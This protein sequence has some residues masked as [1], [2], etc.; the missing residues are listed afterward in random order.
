[1]SEQQYR[2]REGEYASTPKTLTQDEIAELQSA[3]LEGP[4]T[5]DTRHKAHETLLEMLKRPRAEVREAVKDAEPAEEEA[6]SEEGM[7]AEIARLK[8]QYIQR[9]QRNQAELEAVL[10]DLAALGIDTSKKPAEIL[11]AINRMVAESKKEK[12]E[13]KENKEDKKK[14]TKKEEPAAAK[15]AEKGGDHGHGHGEKW[16][17]PRTMG[18]LGWLALATAYGV[19]YTLRFFWQFV[20]HPVIHTAGY[21]LSGDPKHP[22]TS[23]W[24]GFTGDIKKAFGAGKAA[25]AA[26]H[27]GGGG[28]GH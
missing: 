15:A 20:L 17:V 6:E 11:E 18:E 27:S 22:W 25:H 5:I 9:E 10:R 8:E 24:N 2:V 23:F 3:G 4:E 12:E 7:L 26:K 14:E 13:A 21:V 1:V 16:H 28:H 19:G